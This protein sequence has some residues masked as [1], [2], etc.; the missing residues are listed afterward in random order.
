MLIGEP[1]PSQADLHFR[2]FG[3]PVRVHPWFWIVSLML[4]IGG[5]GPADPLQTVLWVL[6]VFVSVL[7]HELG[8]ATLQRRFGGRPHIVLYSF[9]GLAVSDNRGHSPWEQIL[10]LL[11]GPGAGFAFAAVILAAIRLSGRSIEFG[12]F[13]GFVGWIIPAWDPFASP[14]VNEVIFDLLYVNIFWGLVNLLPIYP[15]DGGQI[16]REL[17]T[18]KNPHQGIVTS[19][20]I[21]I[22]AAAAMTV[23]G[24]TRNSLFVAFMFGYLAYASYQTLQAYQSHWR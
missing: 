10:V 7:I 13:Q 22:F 6:I 12:A 23:Y 8:H 1:P 3:I 24:V 20:W 17:F 4:G 9:G 2:V 16:T 15:L 11:G 5:S 21:S 14:V 19:L 18:L